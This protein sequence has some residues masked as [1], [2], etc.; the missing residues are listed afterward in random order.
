MD[1]IKLLKMSSTIQITKDA[2]ISD[3]VLAKAQSH[4]PY[5]EWFATTMADKKYTIHGIHFADIYMFTQNLVGFIYLFVDCTYNNVRK[6]NVIFMRS[7]AVAML[8]VLECDGDEYIILT[9]QPRLATGCSEYEEIPAG[10]LDN[11]NNFKGVAAK[12]LEEEAHISI[13]EKDLKYLTTIV[14]SAGGTCESIRLYAVKLSVTK[15]QLNDLQGKETGNK[16]ENEQI[17]LSVIS[18]KDALD[19]CFKANKYTD[20]KLISA[21][22][23]YMLSKN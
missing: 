8:V 18:M 20:A 5:Q 9:K 15:D 7:D 23:Y 11:S 6:T 1:I 17:R 10:M 16:K 13:T 4:R 19:G 21:L 2:K 22:S 14:P 12:E 3:E